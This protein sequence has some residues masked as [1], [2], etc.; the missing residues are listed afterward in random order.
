MNDRD[1]KNELPKKQRTK[2]LRIAAA[3]LMVLSAA[4]AGGWFGGKAGVRSAPPSY[5]I[6][7]YLD[8]TQ[9][10]PVDAETSAFS[11]TAQPNEPIVGDAALIVGGLQMRCEE[12]TEATDDPAPLPM[13]PIGVDQNGTT[14]VLSS[15]TLRLGGSLVIYIKCE[16]S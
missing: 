2:G 8:S 5:E 11:R 14:Y 1:R 13:T 16:P 7:A 12:D 9:S 15:A 6:S 4:A 10:G 3:A